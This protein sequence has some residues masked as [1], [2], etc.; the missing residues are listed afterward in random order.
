MRTATTTH[1]YHVMARAR[2]VEEGAGCLCA[3]CG[4]SPFDVAGGAHHRAGGVISQSFTNWNSLLPHPH[5]CLGCRALTKGKP[6]SKPKPFREANVAVIDGELLRPSDEEL[7]NLVLKPPGRCVLSWATGTKKHHWMSAGL[8]TPEMVRL[9]SDDGV[10]IYRPKAERRLRDE[11]L[12]YRRV[13]LPRCD[14]ERAAP[15]IGRASEGIHYGIIEPFRQ[16][17]GETCLRVERERLLEHIDFMKSF[18]GRGIL[19][20]FLRAIPKVKAK[21]A[22][23]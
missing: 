11:C 2:G 10:L 17:S 19:D 20:F 12:F 22:E 3:F 23:E 15:H 13:W 16:E 5:V 8:S 21:K 9:G 4:R 18:R 7:L 14:G 1:P 6:G